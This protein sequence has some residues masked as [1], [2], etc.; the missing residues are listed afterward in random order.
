MEKS[1]RIVKRNVVSANRKKSVDPQPEKIKPEADTDCSGTAVTY[2]NQWE[3]F[4]RILCI[5]KNK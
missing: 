3:C 4:T 2:C 5:D 1:R